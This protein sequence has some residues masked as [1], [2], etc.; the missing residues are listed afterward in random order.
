MWGFYGSVIALT[1]FLCSFASLLSSY[2]SLRVKTHAQPHKRYSMA[3][4][5]HRVDIDTDLNFLAR[6]PRK[7]NSPRRASIWIAI[8]IGRRE[9]KMKFKH[10]NRCKAIKSFDVDEIESQKTWQESSERH[11]I[12]FPLS[13]D[14]LAPRIPL[15]SFFS[16][17]SAVSLAAAALAGRHICSSTKDIKLKV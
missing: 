10:V 6:K 12:S 17:L 16:L 11:S 13:I 15:G 7:R 4:K 2:D 8:I 14:L 9:K 3:L 1:A 5:W